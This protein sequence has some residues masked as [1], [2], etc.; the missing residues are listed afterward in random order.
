MKKMI[1]ETNR[2]RQI[3]VDFSRK[4]L[5]LKRGWPDATLDQH[6]KLQA[7][8]RAARISAI[9]CAASRRQKDSPA[10][11]RTLTIRK[12]LADNLLDDEPI[13]TMRSVAVSDPS[14]SI[15]TY[16]GSHLSQA[17]RVASYAG[18]TYRRTGCPPGWSARGA[19]RNTAILIP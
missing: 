10:K 13:K 2:R 17:W 16:R 12:A 1:A 4:L 18:L 8:L 14:A 3:Q 5:N 9:V 11:P 15:T 19:G 6:E 7:R